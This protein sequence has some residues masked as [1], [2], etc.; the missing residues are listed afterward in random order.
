MKDETYLQKF[1]EFNYTLPKSNV[2]TSDGLLYII[3]CKATL[4]KKSMSLPPPVLNT[5]IQREMLI[6]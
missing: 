5:V 4:N 6:Y 2:S 1:K 3:I